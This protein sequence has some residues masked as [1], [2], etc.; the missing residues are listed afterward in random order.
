MKIPHAGNFFQQ[1]LVVPS[2]DRTGDLWIRSL[3]LYQ[4]IC[5]F[6]DLI[7]WLGNISAQYSSW[8]SVRLLIQRSMVR[9][10]LGK[11]K[12][13]WK[14]GGFSFM[15]IWNPESYIL[16]IWKSFALVMTLYSSPFWRPVTWFDTKKFSMSLNEK[17]MRFPGVGTFGGHHMALLHTS[18]MILS[19]IRTY[20]IDVKNEDC[21]LILAW[22]TTHC[23]IATLYWKSKTHS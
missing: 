20:F 16:R 8:Y 9:S 17:V 1:I 4:L 23:H 5:R 12:I 6:M 2:R 11:T 18:L 21:F 13:C 10:L 22:Y 3:T 19:S 14:K 15:V 7:F